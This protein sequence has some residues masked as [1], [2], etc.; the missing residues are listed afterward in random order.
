M[1][2]EPLASHMFVLYFAILS[3]LT[4]PVCPG[5]YVAAGIADADWLKTAW[6][7]VR[8]AIVK[9]I[10]PFMFILNTSLLLHGSISQIIWSVIAATVGVY[11]IAAG[12]MGYLVK[13]L[14]IVMRITLVAGA[15]FCF[16]NDIVRIGIGVIFGV[17]VFIYQKR[18]SRKF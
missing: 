13:N 7:A 5:V 14:G 1:G 15:L 12:T 17:C 10:L 3:V 9:Y 11:M 8:L 16:S 2:F 6:I 4:P 18:I